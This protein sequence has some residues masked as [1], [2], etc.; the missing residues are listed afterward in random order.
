MRK[1]LGQITNMNEDLRVF[2]KIEKE[3]AQMYKPLK[4]FLTV[5]LAFAATMSAGFARD[6]ASTKGGF[7]KKSLNKKKRSG[8]KS[9]GRKYVWGT[10]GLS[11]VSTAIQKDHGHIVSR[12]QRKQIAKNNKKPFLAYRGN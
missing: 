11:A 12:H 1:C 7:N 5:A 9:S 8:G 4:R 10:L 3:V 6:V 2:K